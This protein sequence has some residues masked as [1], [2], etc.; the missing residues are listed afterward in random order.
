MLVHAQ[1]RQKDWKESFQGVSGASMVSSSYDAVLAAQLELRAWGSGEPQW[2]C[3]EGEHK[4]MSYL[5]Y[6]M[7]RISPLLQNQLNSFFASRSRSRSLPDLYFAAR[8]LA[9]GPG[10]DV[11]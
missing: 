3:V 6:L 7:S 10:E 11:Q 2:V 8:T 5:M 1:P 4:Q 9:L